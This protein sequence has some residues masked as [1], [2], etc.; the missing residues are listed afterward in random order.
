MLGKLRWP[1][2]KANSVSYPVL[3]YFRHF[4]F[5]SFVHRDLFSIRTEALRVYCG[6]LHVSCIKHP[7]YV[8]EIYASLLLERSPRVS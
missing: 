4:Y 3:T 2:A 7:M 5:Y 6:R 1:T 8:L